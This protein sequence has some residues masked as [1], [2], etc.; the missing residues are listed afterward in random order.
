MIVWI[1]EKLN[2]KKL[3]VN[4]ESLEGLEKRRT[5]G[6]VL[7]KVVT[8]TVITNSKMKNTD[9]EKSMERNVYK[10]NYSLRSD[11]EIEGSNFARENKISYGKNNEFTPEREQKVEGKVFVSQYINGSSESSCNVNLKS[12]K[13]LNANYEDLLNILVNLDE[14]EIKTSH[15][16]ENSNNMYN[17]ELGRSI[18]TDEPS[19]NRVTLADEGRISVFFCSRTVFN[20]RHRI[21]TEI[22]IKVLEKGLDFASIQRTLNDPELCKDFEEICCRMRCKSTFI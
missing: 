6:E 21:L 16:N 5:F 20:L 1:I 4:V 7:T 12:E 14:T 22:E 13:V 10:A 11:N 9:E 18:A 3:T 19:I 8:N 2:Q 15:I 17:R